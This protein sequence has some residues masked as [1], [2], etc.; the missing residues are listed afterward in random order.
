MQKGEGKCEEGGPK[1]G[2]TEQRRDGKD[3]IGKDD[4][5]V[6]QWYGA[7]PGE[8]AQK[9]G[10]LIFL[11]GRKRGKVDDQ[12]ICKGKRGQRND[13]H[14]EQAMIFFGLQKKSNGR[15]DVRKMRGE[16]QFAKSAVEQAD[17]RNGIRK[18]KDE[19]ERNKK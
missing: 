9:C 1:N 17:G 15:N 6:M 12:K 14:C 4:Q 5:A 2:K 7:F 10:A 19:G 8:A 13:D 11:V 18:D 3:N 16:S